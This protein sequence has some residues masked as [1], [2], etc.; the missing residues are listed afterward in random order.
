MQPIL[1]RLDSMLAPVCGAVA[2]LPGLLNRHWR[3]AIR[4]RRAPPPAKVAATAPRLEP[5][6]EWEMVVGLIRRDLA[7]VSGIAAIQARAVLKID[8]AE[9]AL[10]RIVA[11]CAKVLAPPATP[12]LRPALRLAHRP[13]PEARRPLAA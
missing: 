2:A 13:E 6:R 1:H 9:H 4:S 5:G 3:S 7:R 12:A 11:D 10:N 8:A